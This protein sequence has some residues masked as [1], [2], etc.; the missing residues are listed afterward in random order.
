MKKT[1]F[2][3]TLAALLAAATPVLAGDDRPIEYAKLPTAARQFIASSFA[4]TRVSYAK[5]DSEWW[6]TTYEVVFVDGRKV[7]F[8]KDGSWKEVS[9]KFSEVP[10]KIIPDRIRDYVSATYAGQK[11][12]QIERDRR[13]CEV[14]LDGGLDLIFDRDGNLIGMDD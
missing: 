4:D 1:A 7:E 14:K 9:C 13:T 3:L 8:E 12:V 2:I 6:D 10:A 5:V 11:I